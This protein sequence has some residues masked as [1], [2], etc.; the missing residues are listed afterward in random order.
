[1]IQHSGTYPSLLVQHFYVCETGSSPH[2]SLPSTPKPVVKFQKDIEA[3]PDMIFDTS[4]SA[5]S[6]INVDTPRFPT[7]YSHFNSKQI[8][9]DAEA[10]KLSQLFQNQ[11][12]FFMTMEMFV[13]KGK[14]TGLIGI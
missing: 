1:M 8:S 9:P 13:K 10:K 5:D 4:S 2:K 14:S 12:R 11:V 3:C 7:E 6:A